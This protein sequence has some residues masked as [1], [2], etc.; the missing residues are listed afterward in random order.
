MSP[1]VAQWICRKVPDAV[2][3]AGVVV[4]MIIEEGRP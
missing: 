1:F 4:A 2:G 3:G